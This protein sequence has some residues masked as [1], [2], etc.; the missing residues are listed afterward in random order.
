MY[1]MSKKI[2]TPD[3]YSLK[4]SDPRSCYD[5][6]PDYDFPWS[7]LFYEVGLK[8]SEPNHDPGIFRG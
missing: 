4:N 1:K 5:T 3:S 8:S 2:L 6:R 7:N